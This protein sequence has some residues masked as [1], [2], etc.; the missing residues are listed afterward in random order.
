VASVQ[1][2]VLEALEGARNYNGWLASLARPYL[3]DDP[4]EIGSGR[5]TY[6]A[7]WLEAGIERFTA[8]EIDAELVKHPRDHCTAS[9]EGHVPRAWFSVIVPPAQERRRRWRPPFGQ[10]LFAVGR[11]A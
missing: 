2:S 5:G 1:H 8:T 11:T 6:V 10:S 7:L 4:L 3:G 9:R